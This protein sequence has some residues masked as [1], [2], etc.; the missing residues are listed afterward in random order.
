MKHLQQRILSVLL[1]AACAAS[2]AAAAGGSLTASAADTALP[3][4][5]DL[6]DYN[7]INFV[8]PVHSQDPWGSCWA[9]GSTC[10][11]EVSIQYEI[12][13]NYGITPEQNPIDLSELALTWFAGTPLPEGNPIAPGQ[14]GE[15]NYL[16]GEHSDNDKLDSGGFNYY[17]MLQYAAG[18][19]PYW[20]SE[21]PYRNEDGMV[22]WA[23]VDEDGNIVYDEND[24]P[25][26]EFQ[27]LDWDAPEGYQPMMYSTES[28][29][30]VA[31][32][33]RSETCP[34]LESAKYLPTSGYVDDNYEY[35]YYEYA[36]DM[37][38]EE[39]MNGR[40]I[41]I[42]FCADTYMPGQEVDEPL[43][44]SDNY[45]HYTYDPTAQANHEVCIVGWDD[46]YSRSNFLQGTDD[47]GD[48]K[49]PPADGA[50]I[51][52]NSWGSGS[53]PFPD[54]YPWGIN[55]EGYFYISYYDKSLADP[56]TFDFDVTS[57]LP[58]GQRTA[59]VVD[60]YDLM[61]LAMYNIYGAS[62]ED[63]ENPISVANV[64]SAKENQMLTYVSCFA[65]LEDID[66]QYDVYRLKK[67]A[68]NPTDGELLTSF[69]KHYMSAG[70]Y[71]EPLEKTLAIAAGEQYSI[72]VSQSDEYGYYY[73]M[74]IAVGKTL[75]EYYQQMYDE[76]GWG[77]Y[78][79]G[80]AVGVI[81]KGESWLYFQNGWNDEKDLEVDYSTE[82]YTDPETGEE[83]NLVG[84]YA[85]D[86]YPIKGYS[87]KGIE[88]S[89]EPSVVFAQDSFKAGDTIKYT[90]KVEN[91]S[92]D[93]ALH[94]LTLT[95]DLLSAPTTI[96]TIDPAQIYSQEYEYKVTDAD[97][98][99][100]KIELSF[101]VASPYTDKTFKATGTLLAAG[102]E[103][104]VVRTEPLSVAD[105]VKLARFVAEDPLITGITAANSDYNGDGMITADDVRYLLAKIAKL[106]KPIDDDFT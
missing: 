26:V 49:T 51:V 71:R 74:G 73:C 63:I 42:S 61:P 72:V 105:A 90:F 78:G 57:F 88:V 20:E 50:W 103:P 98:Q 53:R 46:S 65:A 59:M 23:L 104:E 7:G 22:I 48:S 35:T 28:A 36:T 1:S 93:F 70:Y 11:A 100:G 24:Y 43:Y 85:V 12:W 99:N 58:N 31:E 19:G 10:A 5:F 25:Y 86:N 27:T 55:G 18:S 38:K 21:A 69:Q 52:K 75:A 66:V 67:D 97:V 44:M 4:K 89:L 17:T 96:Q 80:Y 16:L 41:S 102:S 94:D 30:V 68:A 77:E 29:W 2:T 83:D 87:I 33:L 45:A 56:V 91:P 95:S 40:A 92:K 79:G 13:K 3:A 15:G 6:R 82:Y 106:D 101:N 64:F 14:A 47:Y 34:S 39:L 37:M 62:R 9:F 8:T 60:Q 76:L 84:A 81:N 32:S 54:N